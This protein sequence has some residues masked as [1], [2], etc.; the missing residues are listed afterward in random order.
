MSHKKIGYTSGVFDMFHIGHLNIIKNAKKNC[1]YL[2][3]A[4]SSDELTFK[5]KNKKPLINFNE[6]I[7]IIKSL[8]YVDKVVQEKKDD[9]IKAWK[10]H[11]YDI[12]FKGSDWRNSKK[13]IK[14]KKFFLKKNV[15]V[16]FFPYT[17]NI[18][19]S[20]LKEKIKKKK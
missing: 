14:L 10:T 9:K 19:T 8:R 17:K 20:S 12:I 16:K 13:W 7:Q 3:V 15:K 5:L 18:S 2:I 6:R 11:K 4:V 1:D